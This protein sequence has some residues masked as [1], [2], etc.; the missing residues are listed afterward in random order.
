MAL[1]IYRPE[2][3]DLKFENGDEAEGL[4]D[5]IIAKHRNGSLGDIRMRFIAAQTKFCDLDSDFTELK[6]PI[7][8][9]QSITVRARG[10]EDAPSDNNFRNTPMEDVPF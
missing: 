5:I 6:T 1:F 2:V 4:A 3:Y 7:Q 9:S 8:E 10:F